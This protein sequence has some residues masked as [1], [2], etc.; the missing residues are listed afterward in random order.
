M[1][2][3]IPMQDGS[4]KSR[5]ARVHRIAIEV[6]KSMGCQVSSDDEVWDDVFFRKPE[7]AMDSS[8]P[9]FT[10]K[11]KVPVASSYEDYAT[12][13]IRIS[14]PVPLCILSLTP[15]LDFHGLE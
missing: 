4:T 14:Q 7:H 3:E 2:I 1:N 11:E 13:A 6:Y 5:R 9:P 10:G 15:I 8:P 12:I